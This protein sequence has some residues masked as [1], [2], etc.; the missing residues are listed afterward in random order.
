MMKEKLNI[1]LL[2]RGGRESAMAAAILRSPR[3]A[4]LHMSGV[5]LPGAIH[6][7]LH[8][9]DFGG[10]E[11]YVREHQIDLVVPGPEAPIVEGIADALHHCGVA[12]IAPAADAARLEGSKEFAKEFMSRHAIPTPRFM[13]VTPEWIEEGY[14]FIDSLQ[15]PYVLKADGLAAGK[16][17]IITATPEEAKD[18]MRE[19]L[20]GLFDQ[21]SHTVIIEE[22][23]PGEECSVFLAVTGEEY[24]F[25]GTARDY[26]RL[27]TGNL[28][29]NT[30]GMG[31]LSPAPLA[32]KEFL[33]KVDRRILRPTLRGLREEG[34]E[35][36][37]FLYL[38]IV[39]SAGEPML[40][41]YNVRLGDPE[42]QSLLPRLVSDFVDVL[43]AIADRHAAAVRPVLGDARGV[44]VVAASQ[45][46]PGPV[47]K[48]AEITG[49]RAAEATGATILAGAMR[50]LP[51][52][53]LL[54]D[55][56]RVLTAVGCAP[57]TPT[58]AA[59]ALEAMER[60]NFEG[61]V[62]RTDIGE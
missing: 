11:E 29:P 2:G 38:G 37:G 22:Y 58:A 3:T 62:Y 14:S 42:S 50:R 39:E 21:S 19:M 4:S 45:G 13:T 46:Y 20:E 32:S 7:G 9:L 34:I 6:S 60:I 10:V 47:T 23:A 33:D 53:T 31:A 30:A 43:A 61:M 25:I 27:K 59:K 26:K 48:G 44:A 1:L 16:G 17:V 12:C 41:E 40:L 15:P 36:N 5:P 54:T 51:D 52:G 56:A 57:D 24:A 49:L 18:T 55:G 35:Y 8:T 28:G